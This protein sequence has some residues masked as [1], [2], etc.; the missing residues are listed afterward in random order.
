MNMLLQEPVTFEDVAVD[1]TQEEWQQLAPAQKTLHRDVMLEIY[2]H[3]VSAGCS[4]LKLDIIS[5]LEHGK[6]PW[7]TESELSRRTYSGREQ[8]SDSCQQIISR[9]LSFQMEI[10]ERA[11]KDNSSYS[12]FKVWYIDGQLD[13]YQGNQGRVLRQI[14]VF[15]HETMTKKRG[16]KCN[17]FGKIFSGCIDLDPSSKTLHHFDS[18]E[19]SLKS[20]LDSLTCNRSYIRKNPIE[21]FGC[22]K[23]LSYSSSCS[24]PE[25]IHVGTK[26]HAHKSSRWEETQCS[27]CG[28]GFVKKSQL[29]IHQ[30]VHTRE[31]LYVCGDCGKA[32]SEKSHLIVH[33]RIHTGEKSYEC[34]ECGK[35][36]SQKSLFIVHQRVHTGEKPYECLEC[37]KAFSQKTHLI[38]QQRL[39][40][41]EK[42]FGFSE[43]GKITHTEE[44]PYESTECGKTFPRKT[45]C[46]PSE[47]CSEYG[48]T[49]GQQIH[50]GEKPYI[51]TDCG[52]AFSQKSHLSGHQR[53]HTGEKPYA[54][55]KCGKAFSQ[56][57]P[58]IIHQRIHI[59]EKLY[60]CSECGKT[61]SQKSP[62][63]IHQ[64]IHTG[65]KP[66]ECQTFS[67]KSHLIL[68]QR[69]YTREKPYESNE[70][71]KA[72]FEKSPL[73]VHQRI[74]TREK[75]SESAEY[76]ITFSQK[77]QMITHQRTHTGDDYGKVFCQQIYLT[78]HQNPLL[79][80]I[81]QHIWKTQQ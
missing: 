70:C 52:K 60:E 8:S 54:C 26:S 62:F 28:K 29:D 32:F 13:R 43:C 56:K 57:S 25:K 39:H 65:E 51:C 66:Y 23:P 36:F 12:V 76:G 27:V 69:A 16:P 4:D 68:H 18:C 48:K 46:H 71:G 79:H 75:P 11:P 40:T 9:E 78:G 41:R 67:L 44:N 6:D 49:F 59:G 55:T 81:C 2:S 1:F 31:K 80:S 35:A 14:T 58:L 63:I 61:F 77:S 19:K 45:A 34:S 15:S 5:K 20:N 73:V 3:L 30:R 72:F 64:R 10:L 17:V 53:L 21:R 38:I 37:Q 22:G 7:I 24:V 74:H 50:T 33:Q 42:P 47:N